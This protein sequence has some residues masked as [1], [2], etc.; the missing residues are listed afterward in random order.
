MRSSALGEDT[1]GVSFAGLYST[2]LNVEKNAISAFYKKVIASKYGPKA[3][4]Y[5]R[6]RGYRHED[7]EM[8]VGCLVMIDAVVSGV[9]YSSDQGEQESEVIRIN[10]TSGI[11]RGVVDGTTVTDLYLVGREKP[12]P[13]V[14][15]RNTPGAGT[16]PGADCQ[17]C[18]TYRQPDQK[19][20]QDSAA[21]GRPFWSTA[22]H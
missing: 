11:A 7:I 12:F 19:T 4:A 2:F 22:G 18:V 1:A 3:I 13:V 21:A 8:C 16:E 15:S 6:R 9:T 14:Y 5:R 17:P 20:C 10:A